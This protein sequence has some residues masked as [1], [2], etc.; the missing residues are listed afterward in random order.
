MSFCYA[1][2]ENIEFFTL[3]LNIV[4]E[5]WFS[6]GSKFY[7]IRTDYRQ[8]IYGSV[9]K[10]RGN[11]IRYYDGQMYSLVFILPLTVRQRIHFLNQGIS[12]SFHEFI[13]LSKIAKIKHLTQGKNSLDQPVFACTLE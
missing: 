13:S 5:L 12:A 3:N 11:Y 9:V 2:I 4:V 6:N 1:K 10:L 8:A 7:D